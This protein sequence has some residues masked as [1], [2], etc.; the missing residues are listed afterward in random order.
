M[1]KN[2]F[3]QLSFVQDLGCF[4]KSQWTL[5]GLNIYTYK[6]DTVHTSK[7]LLFNDSI[8]LDL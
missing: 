1:G 5:E 8:D 2:A 6:L 4:I 7:N 3:M